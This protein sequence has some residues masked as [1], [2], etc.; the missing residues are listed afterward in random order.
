MTKVTCAVL[1]GILMTLLM[2]G[3]TLSVVQSPS[4]YTIFA[5]IVVSFFNGLIWYGFGRALFDAYFRQP[6]PTK[7]NEED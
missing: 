3:V 4:W 1:T 6:W 5:L 7:R 2:I